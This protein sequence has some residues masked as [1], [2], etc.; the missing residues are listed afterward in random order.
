VAQVEKA[1]STLSKRDIGFSSAKTFQSFPAHPMTR[2]DGNE[3]ADWS[4]DW[5]ETPV[6]QSAQKTKKAAPKSPTSGLKKKSLKQSVEKDMPPTPLGHEWRE[7]EGGWNL[8]RCWSEQDEMLGK[9]IKKERYA[10]YLSR[11]AW[12]VMKEHDHEKIISQIGQQL[13]RH[14]GR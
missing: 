11:Q 12:R 5:D 13:R 3:E 4:L 10:G 8:I 1:H 14:S 2:S 7:T 6:R 9:K